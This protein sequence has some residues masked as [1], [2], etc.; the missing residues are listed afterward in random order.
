M[1]QISALIY[2][3]RIEARDVLSLELRPATPGV[4]FPAAQAGA[5]VD[6]HLAPGLIRSYSLI[7]GCPDRYLIAVLKDRASRGGSRYV[8]E[9]LRVG[10]T[11]SLGAPR[12]HFELDESA[13]YTVLLAGG[14]GITPIYAMLQRLAALERPGQLIYCARSRADAA[15]LQEI[16]A[17]IA[18]SPKLKVQYHWDDV[19]GQ[20]PDLGQLLAEAPEEAHFYCCGPERMLNAFEATCARLGYQNVHIER[21]AAA[22][23]S[24]V[25]ASPAGYPVEL[26]KSGKKLNVAPGE[27]LLDALLNAGCTISYSCRE[28]ICGSCETRVLSGDIDHRDSILT[29]AERLANKSMMPCVSGCKSGTLVLEA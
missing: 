29:R 20:A 23:P 26:R 2:Q 16:E 12:N 14:I 9:S 1:S 10:Q 8:H 24:A 7:Q 11:I 25:A 27:N 6:L 19:E 15:Y 4:P 13:P 17:L 22:A 21:F 18:A 5:H 28:G 3:M